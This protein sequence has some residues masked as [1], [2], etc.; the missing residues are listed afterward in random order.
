VGDGKV[1]ILT[2][3]PS[4]GLVTDDELERAVAGATVVAVNRSAERWPCDYWCAGDVK[5]F[6]KFEPAGDPWNGR[7]VCT[8][9]TIRWYKHEAPDELRDRFMRHRPINRERLETRFLSYQLW[10]RWS[11]PMALGFVCSFRRAREVEIFGCDMLGISDFTGEQTGGRT[12]RRWARER[13]NI[14]HIVRQM[15]RHGYRFSWR[16][17]WSPDKELDMNN[18]GEYI[19]SRRI[20]VNGVTFE[21]GTT[22]KEVCSRLGYGEAW[23]NDVIHAGH[24]VKADGGNPVGR[25]EAQTA[26]ADAQVDESSEA[27]EPASNDDGPHA[28]AHAI[29]LAEDVGLDITTIKGTG[30]DGKVTKADVEAAIEAQTAGG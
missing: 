26:G 21:P 28:S 13:S 2:A 16:G 25:I 20:V 11:M 22:L 23:G 19:A 29:K 30:H 1:V 7:I 8:Q 24:F 18:F 17:L 6:K 14:T 5:A 10:M 9:E 3:G 4:L 12:Q 15:E 27:E